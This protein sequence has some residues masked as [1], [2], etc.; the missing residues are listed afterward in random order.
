METSEENFSFGQFSLKSFHIILPFQTSDI[1]VLCYIR[2]DCLLEGAALGT[3]FNW[4][5]RSFNLQ[6]KSSSLFV[7]DHSPDK[8]I[9]KYEK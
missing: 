7:S 6:G 3:D 5:N 4:S 8:Q 2:H 9:Q 1:S